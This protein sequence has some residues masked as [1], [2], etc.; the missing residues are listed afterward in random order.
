M[1][2]LKLQYPSSEGYRIHEPIIKPED[3]SEPHI[4][5]SIPDE[6]CAVAANPPSKKSK[7]QPMF[8][9]SDSND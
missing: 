4:L 2:A 5:V 1:K 7:F 3:G 9:L 6:R 8:V